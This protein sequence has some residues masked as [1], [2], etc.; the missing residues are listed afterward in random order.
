MQISDQV[1]VVGSGHPLFGKVGVFKGI[2]EPSEGERR[3]FFPGVSYL[4]EFTLYP[5]MSDDSGMREIALRE[6]E[7]RLDGQETFWALY[8]ERTAAHHGNVARR[9]NRACNLWRQHRPAE[10]IDV[11]MSCHPI[12]LALAAM[13]QPRGFRHATR[14]RLEPLVSLCLNAGKDVRVVTDTMFHLHF[15]NQGVREVCGLTPRCTCMEN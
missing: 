12:N 3:G 14:L 9:A 7:L 13:I 2:L 8:V 4:V 5:P 1:R 10:A 11:A 6:P 15:E